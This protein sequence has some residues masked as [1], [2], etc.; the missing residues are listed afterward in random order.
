MNKPLLGNAHLQNI[1]SLSHAYKVIGACGSGRGKLIRHLT[2]MALC[3]EENA[4]CGNCLSCGKVSRGTHPDV[5]VY[6]ENKALN[7]RE[8]RELREDVFI[9]PN[10]GQRKIYVIHQADFLNVQGQNALLK[11]LEEPPA[12]ALFFLIAEEGGE[13]LETISSRCQTLRLQALPQGEI[14]DYLQRE[15][16]QG[17]NLPCLAESCGGY[18]GRAIKA[19]RPPPPPVE[20]QPE[21]GLKQVKKKR[22]SKKETKDS[23]QEEIQWE[24]FLLPLEQA[25]LSGGELQV[26][27]ATRPLAKLKKDQLLLFLTAF[28]ARLIK[29][30]AFN[31]KAEIYAWIKTVEEILSAVE[32]NVQ[33]EQITTWLCASLSLAREERKIR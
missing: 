21:Q 6:G 16:P 30:L 19:L 23:K 26:L 1:K 18:L 2:A 33:G 20:E 15:F 22:V 17:E 29:I 28:Y 7:V 5:L 9:R 14:L 25:L 31:K 11:I 12:Y 27:E 8:V 32:S 24:S 3:Q 10:E 13:L 4:P